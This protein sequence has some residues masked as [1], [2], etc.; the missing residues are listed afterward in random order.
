[1]KTFSM[2]LTEMAR[3]RR[4]F[5]HGTNTEFLPSIQSEGLRNPFLTDIVEIARE[6]AEAT[7]GNGEPVILEIHGAEQGNFDIDKPSL[8]E[9][10]GYGHVTGK[11]LDDKISRML[12]RNQNPQWRHT[13]AITRTV[14]Y[15]GIIP[16]SQIR[17]FSQ[18]DGT[19]WS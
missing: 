12:K 17:V 19:Q 3:S 1:M 8:S 4:V 7:S 16:P 15:N 18:F 13:F 9:P 2:W 14:K 11:E 10:V 5:Y 6:Y